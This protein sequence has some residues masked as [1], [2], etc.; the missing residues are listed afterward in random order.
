MTAAIPS[1]GA[2]GPLEIH[3]GVAQLAPRI[4]ELVHQHDEVVMLTHKDADGDTLGCSLAMAEVVEALH[5]RAYV[6][7]PPPVPVAYAFMAGYDRLN[8]H[9][10]PVT[11]P[12]LVFAFDTASLERSGNSMSYV[13][14]DPV[15]VN[16]DH[17][18]SNTR[19]GTL[20]LV[21]PGAAA[22][23]EVLYDLL[24]AGNIPISP[25]VAGNLYAAL[26]FD[27]G[28]FR[29]DNTSQR[30]LA[31]GADLVGLGADAAAIARGLFKSRRVATLKLHALVMSGV[32]FEHNDQIIWAE[33]TERMLRETH[34]TH[35]DGEGIIDQL[36]SVEGGRFA[37]LFKEVRPELTKISVRTRG[38]ADANRLAQE[39]G[40]GGHRRAAG[41]EIALS[42]KAAEERVLEAARRL[43]SPQAS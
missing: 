5:K 1:E 18:V 7:C 27:T 35:Q 39:F 19:F 33:V 42:L 25:T 17:H 13:G 43:L 37:I 21:L 8:Q 29:H 2:C 26:L 16:I 20:N 22:T 31:M 4:W 32:H 36:S 30:V 10:A 38:E 40:G 6:I 23:A 28:G 12:R 3:P 11:K 14:A 24:R 34:A 9:P 41:A 15:V